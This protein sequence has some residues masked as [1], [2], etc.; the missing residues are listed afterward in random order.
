MESFS[1]KEAQAI[2][3]EVRVTNGGFSLDAQKELSEEAR[4][5]YKNL[6]TIASGSI[7]HV[8][9]DLYDA[10]TRFIF[11][12]IQNAEDNRYNLAAK[13]EEEPFLHFT[14]HH[15]HLT[16]DSNEDGFSDNDVRSICSIH[17]SSKKQVGGYIGHK[18]IGFKSVFKIAHKVCIQS[19]PF[20]FSFEYR[21]GDS[22]LCMITPFNQTLQELPSTVKTRIT[23][24][25]LRSEDFYTRGRELKEIPDTL[26]LFL[27]KLR[28]LTI[29]TPT[30][31]YWVSYKRHENVPER[32]VTLMKQ[33]SDDEQKRS[34]YMEKTTLSNL[35]EHHS[36][37]EQRETDLILAF[38]VDES[39]NPVI[40]P[41]YVYSFLPM[42]HEGFNVSTFFSSP[43]NN[44]VNAPDSSLFSLT[45]SPKPTAKEFI[46]ASGTISS[47]RPL[48]VYLS[49]L[50]NTSAITKCWHMNGCSIFRARI[51]TTAS[52]QVFET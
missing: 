43:S 37:R 23:L 9:E 41:Q 44:I 1:I 39:F 17:R 51:F 36:R 14:L 25:L 52:G 35:P 49:G 20:C 48:A 40:E 46:C 32:L 12:L 7:L 13:C 4:R 34:Y 8:A 42:R 10:D 27:R 16:I 18:G 24:Y 2:V 11:E 5:A 38:P 6:Q 29:E 21:R 47:V 22:G 19:G 15:D 33:T 45:S 50:H 26:L 3:D 28:V 30:L 31:Q